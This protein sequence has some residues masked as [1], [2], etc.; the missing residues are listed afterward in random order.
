MDFPDEVRGRWPQLA[1]ERARPVGGGLI[2]GTW[3]VPSREGVPR[4]VQRVNAI[5]DPR[6]HENIEAVTEWLA[7]KG[8]STPRLIPTGRGERFAASDAGVFRVLSRLPGRTLDHW[9][10]PSQAAAAGRTLA[11]LHVALTDLPH[12]FVGRR[13]GVH[14]TSAHLAT[15]RAALEAHG[16]HRL[17]PEVGA[18]AAEIFAASAALAPIPSAAVVVGHGDPKAANLMVS[19]DDLQPYAWIDLDTVGPIE[20]AHELGDALRSWC[21]AGGEDAAAPRFDLALH[22][23]A[24]RGYVTG[25]RSEAIGIGRAEIATAL[26]VG[27]PWICLELSARFAADALRESYFGWDP[28]AFEGRGEHNLWRAR[29][30]W[31][32]YRAVIE[33]AAARRGQIASALELTA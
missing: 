14:D 25:A 24:V 4:I 2:N 10:R 20:L 22:E 7:R 5:F 17:R 6:V 11:S 23:A 13:L 19:S 12:E 8:I 33:H 26:E 16:D 1:W 32:L 29:G 9:G 18:I 15:L 3:E 31:A 27:L 30:Q 21:N 28:E